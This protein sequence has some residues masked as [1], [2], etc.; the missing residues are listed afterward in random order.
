MWVPVLAA[1]AVAIALAL[2][3]PIVDARLDEGAGLPI[4]R[5]RRDPVIITGL[6]LPTA[7]AIYALVALA[8]IGRQSQRA[9]EFVPALTVVF[10]LALLVVTL[11][12]FV[13]LVQRAFDLTQIGGILRGLMRRAYAVML[14]LTEVRNYGSHSV[15]QEREL[16]RV[17]DPIGLGGR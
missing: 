13:A 1:N 10:G 8:A 2:I 9:P 4:A 5:L 17:P 3:L 6:A 16:A 12:A 14:A 11:G 15:R 7:T